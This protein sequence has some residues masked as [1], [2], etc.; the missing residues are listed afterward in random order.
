[1]TQTENDLAALCQAQSEELKQL[2]QLLRRI[3][4]E[5]GIVFDHQQAHLELDDYTTAMRS[6]SLMLRK[7]GY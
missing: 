7:A 5:A 2:K 3:R 1:M 4:F 6:I